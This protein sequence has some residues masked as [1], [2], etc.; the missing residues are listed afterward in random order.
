MIDVTERDRD[1]FHN[2]DKNKV[3]KANGT[4]R[5]DGSTLSIAKTFL[6]MFMYIVISAAVAFGV[7]A[8]MYYLIGVKGSEE[9]AGAYIGLLIGSGIA[10]FIDMI[11][12]NF[13]VIKGKHSVLIPGIIYAVLIGALLSVLTIFVNWELIGIALG[14]T[15]LA[16]LIMSGIAFISKGNMKPL[17]IALIGLLIGVGLISAFNLISMLITGGVFNF[18]YWIV[19]IG[20]FLI[21]ILVTIYDLWR[22]K[23]IADSGAMTNNMSLYFAFIMYTDFI[24]VFIRVLYFVILFL[25]KVKK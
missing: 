1:A 4:P 15:A 8:L 2:V 13:V 9:A 19:S 25:G 10:L 18:L 3:Y 23:Q 16:F 17:S 14:I 21:I 12:I 5:A 24:N 22:M 11:V 7:G 20:I 6:Y